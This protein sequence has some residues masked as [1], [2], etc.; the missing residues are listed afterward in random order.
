MPLAE[1]WHRSLQLARSSQAAATAKQEAERSKLRGLAGAARKAST[2]N[3]VTALHRMT[4]RA[5]RDGADGAVE[6][7]REAWLRQ[8]EEDDQADLD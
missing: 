1:Q 4:L 7:L 2:A 8:Q 5:S 6:K 3:G